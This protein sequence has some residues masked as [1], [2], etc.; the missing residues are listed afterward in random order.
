MKFPRKPNRVFGAVPL[1]HVSPKLGRLPRYTK[2]A[3]WALVVFAVIGA[4]A[5]A[6]E[7]PDF[8]GDQTGTNPI[9]FTFDARVYNEFVWLN[10]AGDGHQNL[11]TL[12]Y[13]QPF[14][15]G[16]FQFRTRI[17]TNWIE[18]DVNGDGIDD[19]D[20]FGLGDVDIRILT[21]PYLNMKK[22]T[23]VALGFETFLPT[24]TDKTLGSQRLSFGPQIFGVFFAPFGI[25]GTLIAPAYQHKF[26][27]WEKDNLRNLHQGLF[28]LF[29][30]WISPDKQR[31]A[32]LDPQ[33]II[34]YKEDREFGLIDVEFGTMLDKLLGTKGH[35]AYIR[36]SVGFARDRPTDG[37]IE[38]GYKIVW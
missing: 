8:K 18:A 31:W 32:L 5:R 35:S 27:V 26:S 38:L 3:A 6:Q 1:R 34:D 17:R 9:N 24:P 7:K 13:R 11:T 12:E 37:A 19:V 29:L 23:A 10:T 22:R 4:E 14:A 33:F 36:P 21:V 2:L 28:D 20:E 25:K 16:K 15:D 30:L